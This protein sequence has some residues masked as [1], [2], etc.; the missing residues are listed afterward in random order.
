MR[1]NKNRQYQLKVQKF[2]Q[3]VERYKQTKGAHQETIEMFDRC[4]RTVEKLR[5]EHFAFRPKQVPQHDYDLV[6]HYCFMAQYHINQLK[7]HE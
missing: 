7:N 4:L 5:K 1:R 3:L 2:E 6:A